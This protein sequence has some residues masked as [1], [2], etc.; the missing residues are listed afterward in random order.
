MNASFINS[1]L[2]FH[3]NFGEREK[4]EERIEIN[5]MNIINNKI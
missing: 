3:Y 2:Y 5:E 1:G 4:R